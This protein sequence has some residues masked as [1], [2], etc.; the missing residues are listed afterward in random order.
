MHKSA[1]KIIYWNNLQHW[2]WQLMITDVLK[3][4]FGYFVHAFFRWLNN[5]LNKSS[6]NLSFTCFKMYIMNIIIKEIHLMIYN[7]I[8][9]LNENNIVSIY[10]RYFMRKQIM[11]W[12]QTF[13]DN[14]FISFLVSYVKLSKTS[15]AVGMVLIQDPTKI[16]YLI[17]QI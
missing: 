15:K 12:F 14:I 9:F 1:L 17:N 6:K 13:Y 2:N 5:T 4:S 3:L 11:K 8:F 10:L 16:L 7:Y